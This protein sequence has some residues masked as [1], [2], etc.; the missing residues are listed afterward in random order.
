MAIQRALISSFSWLVMVLVVV[1]TPLRC[2]ADNV[3][4]SGESLMSGQFLSWGNY[5]FIMQDDCNLVLYDRGNAIWSSN[6]SGRGSNC[7]LSQQ[8]DGNLVVYKPDGTTAL[9]SSQT[10]VGGEGHYVLVLQ[11]DRKVVLYGGPRWAI[12]TYSP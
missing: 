9:W 10:Y 12:D 8:R 6:T 4:Y 11:K 2:R 1:V 5:K 3:L 7:H